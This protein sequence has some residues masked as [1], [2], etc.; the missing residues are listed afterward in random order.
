MAVLCLRRLAAALAQAL[1]VRE[2]LSERVGQC[3]RRDRKDIRWLQGPFPQTPGL[4]P[5]TGLPWERMTEAELLAGL[6]GLLDL[7]GAVER[8]ADQPP[9]PVEINPMPGTREGTAG[10][11]PQ[12]SEGVSRCPPAGA[13]GPS[14]APQFC[15]VQNQ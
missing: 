11:V 2:V 1:D 6:E 7:P 12:G 5:D 4:N 9:K 15:G 13:G 8:V 3:P 10:V 14:D